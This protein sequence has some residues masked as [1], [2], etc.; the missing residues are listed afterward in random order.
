MRGTKRLGSVRWLG[1][2]VIVLGLGACTHGSKHADATTTTTTISPSTT[3]P[4]TT[5]ATAPPTTAPPPTPAL[6]RCHDDDLTLTVGPVN[7]AAGTQ[8]FLIGFRNHSAFACELTGYPGVSFLAASGDEIGPPARRNN[9]PYAPVTIAPSAKV[10][11]QVGVG[12]PGV[13][14]CAGVTAH[15]IRVFPP[16]ETAAILVTPPARLLVCPTQGAPSV[17]PV[18]PTP[19]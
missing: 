11:A 2:F 4:P 14:N 9:V 17:G 19:I 12:N 8:Y 16:N 6:G 13:F 18:T 5:V 7:G 15:D 3:L 1:A 10:Y